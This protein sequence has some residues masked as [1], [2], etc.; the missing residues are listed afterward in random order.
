[1]NGFGE[2]PPVSRTDVLAGW[3]QRNAVEGRLVM[4]N[5]HGCEQCD[6]T[7]FKSRAGIHEMMVISRELRR[8]IQNGSRAEALQK[9]AMRK[10]CD[11]APGRH[12]QGAGRPDDDRGSAGHEQ[13]LSGPV[14]RRADGRA[15]RLRRRAPPVVGRVP[16]IV[17]MNPQARTPP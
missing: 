15:R 6:H 4:H 14:R 9:T 10:A 11:A 16:M 12:R 5:S 2:D 13:H 8:M 17:S 1:M 3:T 7:G